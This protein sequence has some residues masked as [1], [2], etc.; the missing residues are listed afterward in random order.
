M[1]GTRLAVFA[2]MPRLGLIV[3]DEEHDA[4]FKQQEGLRYS[5]RDLAL[6][7]AKLR[8]VPIVLGSA[9]PSLESYAHA[10]AGRY[11]LLELPQRAAAALP[12][13]R[14]VDT[15]HAKSFHGLTPQL[16]DAVKARMDRREQSL[17]FVNRRGYAPALV[18]SAC[19]W[20]SCCPRCSAKLV[21]HLRDRRLCCHYC[22]H[23]ARIATACAACGNQDLLPAG[24]GTQRI[25]QALREALPGALIVRVDRDSTRGR[26][27]F[28]KLQSDVRAQRVDVL[29]GTQMLVKGHDFPR[30]TLVGVLN[31]DAT[32]FSPDFRATERL[33]AQLTQVAGRAGRAALPGE[34]LIQTAFPEHPLY[35][36]VCKQD[37]Q[38]FAGAA[39]RERR[40]THFP[41]YAF[42][43]L[44]RAEAHRREA[45]DA[46]LLQAAAAGMA[47]DAA[48][49]IYDP[50]APAIAR[51]AGMER[52]QLLVQASSRSALQQFLTQW[53]TQLASRT[54]RWSLDVDPLDF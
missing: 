27:A 46:Y 16:I 6:F 43:A 17:V 18:C 25:E 36:A 9:T 12:H 33:Y 39:L 10:R 26:D 48:V 34:V 8:N 14:T 32:L 28:V 44:L 37:Y 31:A 22:G 21:L 50:V 47:I 45:V 35:A 49:E 19:G 24:Q 51:V 7:R 4:S 5:A 54:V 13:I 53:V 1:I 2:P 40:D 20:A 3:V 15:R 11:R 52:G 41:P 42:Q 30:I 38:S 23:Q 29:V